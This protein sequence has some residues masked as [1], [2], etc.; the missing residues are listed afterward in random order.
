MSPDTSAKLDIAENWDRLNDTIIDLVD[1]IP[2]NKL[3]WSPQDDLWDFHHVLS[4]LVFTRHGW[5]GNSVTQ[6]IKP[7]EIHEAMAT[8]AG[9]QEALRRSWARV[10]RF[11]SDE[12]SLNRLFEGEVEGQSYSHRGHWIAFHLLEHDIHHRSDIFHYL[13]LLKIEHPDVGTP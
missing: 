5:M 1:Y 8:R 9:S 10:R 11:L 4:H 12:T 6:K 13:A 7:E 3:D 2:E